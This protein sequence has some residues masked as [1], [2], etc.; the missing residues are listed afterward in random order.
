M[1]A[2][3]PRRFIAPDAL[4]WL[5]L[6]A[7]YFLIPLIATLIF[8]LRSNQTGACCT[9]ENYGEIIHDPQFAKT[10]KTSFILSLETT[11]LAGLPCVCFS[12]KD[13]GPG[14]PAEALPTLFDPFTQVAYP[15]QR[16]QSGTG[17]GL[18]I[19]RRFARLLGGE[20]DVVSEVGVGSTFSLTLP[21]TYK[22]KSETGSWRPLRSFRK[23]EETSKFKPV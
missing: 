12:V 18:A 17:L 2:L 16:K 11:T 20:I 9:L 10:I 4:V 23:L 3:T 6:G 7:A 13:T 22:G 21:T 19:T 8:S 15:A 5:L 14:I 1:V